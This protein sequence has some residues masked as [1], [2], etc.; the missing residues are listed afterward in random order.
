MFRIL[1]CIIVV[2]TCAALPAGENAKM[3]IVST[4]ANGEA[5]AEV[6]GFKGFDY[7]VGAERLPFRLHI[8]QGQAPASGWPLL[9]YIHGM[10]SIGSDNLKPLTLGGRFGSADFQ[11][12]HPCYVLVPQCPESDRW[13]KANWSDKKHAFQ[14]KPTLHMQMLMDLVDRLSSEYSID[15]TRI[16]VGGASM[17]GFATWDIITRL[18]EKF[19]AAYPICGG[20]DLAN[21]Q[22]ISKIPLWCF[23]GAL[24]TTV[25]VSSSREMIEALRAAGGQPKYTEYPDV[26]H[27]AWDRALADQKLFDWLFEQQR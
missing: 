21:A 7:L 4:A 22:L 20:C 1:A 14:E 6:N 16:Y 3:D 13:V 10:G 26:K 15:A 25:P 8:P 9:I 2:L 12:R 5:Y 23:H 11:R 27:D 17:G 19:A 24:D 18:P